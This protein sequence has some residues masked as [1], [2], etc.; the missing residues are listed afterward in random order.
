MLGALALARK[1]RCE[2]RHRAA[3]IGVPPFLGFAVS[4]Q[5]LPIH[6]KL[7]ISLLGKKGNTWEITNGSQDKRL[8]G[9]PEPRALTLPNLITS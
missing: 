2:S 6:P 4:E 3:G 1:Q 8:S 5:A 7:P 9:L